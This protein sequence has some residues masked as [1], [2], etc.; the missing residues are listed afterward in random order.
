MIY[1]RRDKS[2]TNCENKESGRASLHVLDRGGASIPRRG[3]MSGMPRS[4]KETPDPLA[5]DGESKNAKAGRKMKATAMAKQQTR[6]R[7][8]KNPSPS[9]EM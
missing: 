2:D 6:R 4:Q 1:P 8:P 5:G 9:S 7:T 3:A